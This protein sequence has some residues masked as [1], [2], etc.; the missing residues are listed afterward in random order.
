MHGI[1]HKNIFI[2]AFEYPFIPLP[3]ILY[4]RYIKNAANK[5]SQKVS[6]KIIPDSKS[7]LLS[8][9]STPTKR[10]RKNSTP[11]VTKAMSQA[12]PLVTLYENTKIETDTDIHNMTNSILQI[13]SL[14]V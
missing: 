4:T 13:S 7:R 6:I 8:P 10:I 2:G 14:S 9:T 1:N 5:V 11:L 3:T 12:F